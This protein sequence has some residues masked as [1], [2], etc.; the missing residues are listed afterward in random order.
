MRIKTSPHDS[1]Q[2][3]ISIGHE[4]RHEHAL[5][6]TMSDSAT[7]AAPG[8]HTPPSMTVTLALD[9]PN[10]KEGEV[11]KLSASIVS[12]ATSPVTILTHST[13]LDLRDAQSRKM[14]RPNFRCIDLD[15]NT[16]VRLQ[17]RVCGRWS[18]IR[19]RLDDADSKYFHSLWP[20][21]PYEICAPCVVPHVKLTPGHRYRLHLDN[22]QAIDWW[23]QGTKEEVLASPGQEPSE[24][25]LK[26]SGGP[27]TV[28][29]VEPVDFTVPI[30][31]ENIGASVGSDISAIIGSR[32]TGATAPPLVT[33]TL[34]L[35]TSFGQNISAAELSIVLTSHAQTPI[36]IWIWTSMLNMIVIQG[37]DGFTLTHLDTDTLIPARE[38]FR[39]DQDGLVHPKNRYFHTLL[40]GQPYRFRAPFTPEFMT[41]LEQR[42]GRYRL[43]VKGTEK[44]DWWKEGKREDLVAPIGQKPFENMYEASGEPIAL[45]AEPIEF[46][47]P[48][49]P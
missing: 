44:L 12:H 48:A 13:F 15:T 36:T 32:P 38:M 17:D 30:D 3:R 2:V 4:H 6:V 34:C 29:H 18:P 28:A 20:K 42:P 11:V 5:E 47:I 37:R 25:M 41:K 40:P 24:A 14:G 33:T 27:I 49:R 45:A 10:F 35:D 39:L 7:M 19:H 21:I 23:R 9:P 1:N 46:T 31:W 26:P 16:P 43:A 22:E 8:A